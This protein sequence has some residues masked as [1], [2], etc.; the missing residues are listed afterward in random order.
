MKLVTP[1]RLYA[2]LAGTLLSGCTYEIHGEPAVSPPPTTVLEYM[3][4]H[5]WWT[6][7]Y[8]LL[9]NLVLIACV[10]FLEH[11][12]SQRLNSRNQHQHNADRL[13]E[14]DLKNRQQELELI[15]QGTIPPTTKK[16]HDQ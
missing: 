1:A 10:A 3:H 8:V 6:F 7:V 14:L 11:W 16:D 13:R 5:P 15:A 9:A 12:K 4:A 2:L